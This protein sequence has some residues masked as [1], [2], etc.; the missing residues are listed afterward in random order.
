MFVSCNMF[1]FYHIY[2]GNDL[3]ISFSILLGKM[4]QAPNTLSTPP[5]YPLPL[6]LDPLPPACFFSSDFLCYSLGVYFHFSLFFTY[7]FSISLAYTL[8]V[9]LLYRMLT[10]GP[11]LIICR[12]WWIPKTPSKVPPMASLTLNDASR[13]RIY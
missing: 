3:T 8:F 7:A 6:T 2:N 10:L 4:S 5:S 1:L 12:S 13:P 11:P 9:M